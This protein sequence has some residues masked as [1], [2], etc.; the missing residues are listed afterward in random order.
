[1]RSALKD[2]TAHYSQGG[3]NIRQLQH[4]SEGWTIGC[5]QR[6]LRAAIRRLLTMK[7]FIVQGKSGG[8]YRSGALAPVK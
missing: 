8:E 6:D 7:G 4:R 2:A 5:V 1:M 3:G